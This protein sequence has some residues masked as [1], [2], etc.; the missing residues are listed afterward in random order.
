MS[1]IV[2]VHIGSVF[3]DYINTCVTQCL[4]YKLNVHLVVSKELHDFIENTDNIVL[5]S[6]E[7]YIT[8]EFKQFNI[9]SADKDFRDGFWMSTS[10]RFFIISE[11]AKRNTL[12]SFFHIENDNLIYTDLI[13]EGHV[14]SNSEYNMSVVVDAGPRCVP[15]I[16]WFRNAEIAND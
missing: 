8:T 15:S 3:Y 2:L 14:L 13:N 4:K 11:Y 10:L 16:V 12:T 9:P 6:V 7:D 5:S 1:N